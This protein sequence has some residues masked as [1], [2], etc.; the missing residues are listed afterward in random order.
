M[1]GEA[2][3]KC[4]LFGYGNVQHA[5]H[6]WKGNHGLWYHLYPLPGDVD[7]NDAAWFPFCDSMQCDVQKKCRVLLDDVYPL[8]MSDRRMLLTITCLKIQL[9]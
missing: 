5:V 2:A 7:L 3:E 4:V 9:P 1:R 6:G 8:H